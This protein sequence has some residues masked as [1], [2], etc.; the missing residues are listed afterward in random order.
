MDPLE[1]NA[2]SP[3]AD[4]LREDHTLRNIALGVGGGALLASKPVRKLAGE[5]WGAAGKPGE[6]TAK[7]LN[8][9]VEL[10][11]APGLARNM[12]E[13]TKVHMDRLATANDLSDRILNG[14]Y[15]HLHGDIIGKHGNEMGAALAEK[16]HPVP[17]RTGLLGR[18]LPTAQH[19]AKTLDR[20]KK[21]K[22]STHGVTESVNADFFNARSRIGT[23]QLDDVQSAAMDAYSST[24]GGLPIIEDHL[25]R[26]FMHR[27]AK[28]GIALSPEQAHYLASNYLNK[29]K[30]SANV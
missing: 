8:A 17:T 16:L 23:H 12:G 1:Q 20:I 7:A 24:T 19:D 29:V 15:Q 28:K 5:L 11:G 25:S 10:T 18:I 3:Y 30:G 21:I 4:P 27:M 22:S 13:K 14:K 9:A 6:H 2:M 26:T